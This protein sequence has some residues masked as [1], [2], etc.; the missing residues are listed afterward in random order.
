[1]M[2]YRTNSRF[3]YLRHL[4]DSLQAYYVPPANDTIH[5]GQEQGNWRGLSYLPGT[6]TAD[7]WFA[8][9]LDVGLQNELQVYRSTSSAATKDFLYGTAGPIVPAAVISTSENCYT[10]HNDVLFHG[11][12]RRGLEACLTCHG[13]GGVTSNLL[14]PPSV[15]VEFRQMLH[16]IHMGSALPGASAT[17][18]YPF[19]TGGAFPAM[20]GEAKQCV[21][22]HGNDAWQQPAPRA[23]PSATVPVRIW[24]VIC[25]SCHDSVPAKA[26]ID[27]NTPGGVEACDVCHGPSKPLDVV[28]VHLA[29]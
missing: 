25:G 29:R 12:G 17:P 9:N 23:H 3:G 15:A 10:C 16:K 24:G 20:P 1:V 27:V 2:T 11:G 8:R 6:Y 4:G 21:R 26:H 19:A 7:V 28:K 13:V 5:I 18:P 22:C 14:T